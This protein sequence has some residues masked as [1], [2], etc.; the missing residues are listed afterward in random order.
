M[1]PTEADHGIRTTWRK[2]LRGREFKVIFPV[3]AVMIFMGV[4]LYSFA[5]RSV[6]DFANERIREDLERTSR[7][8][9]SICDSAL[10]AL[11][12]T[13]LS[14]NEVAGRIKRGKVLGEIEAYVQQNNLTAI[15]YTNG[16]K[17]VLFSNGSEL[18]IRHVLSNEINETVV[19]SISFDSKIYYV[20]RFQFELWNWHIVLIK[21]GEVYADLLARVNN[22]YLGTTSILIIAG[23][24]LMYYLKRITKTEMDLQAAKEAAEQA[25]LAKSRFLASASHDLR[26]PM[27]TVSLLAGLLRERS[28]VHEDRDLIDKLKRAVNVM[29]ELFEN[30]L[31][32]SRLDGG[33]IT[34]NISE[35]PIAHLLKMIKANYEPHAAS[36]GLRLRV[37]P[38]SAVIRSDPVLL[39]S[40]LSNLVSNAI[41]YTDRG[42]IL[43]GCSRRGEKLSIKVIDTGIGI[44][45]EHLDEI[46]DEF[47]QLPE[48]RRGRN[49][50]LGLGLSIARRYTD[51]LDHPMC[52]RSVVGSGSMFFVDVPRVEMILS[53]ALS[54]E[55]P[56]TPA[57]ELA[58]AFVV[59]IDDDPHNLAATESLCRK[60]GGRTLAAESLQKAIE[61]LRHHLRVPDLI[62]CDYHLSN[63]QNGLSAVREIR[64][65][66]DEEIPAIFVTGDI[67]I[68][69]ESDISTLP[70]A[71]VL[72]KPVNTDRLRESIEHIQAPMVGSAHAGSVAGRVGAVCRES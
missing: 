4:G 29:E 60:W 23:L 61:E 12:V 30:L 37:S 71:L 55:V 49:N 20:R 40:I 41:R 62:I 18:V 24:L 64:N 38:C 59:I 21:D 58:G 56:P 1:K 53:P 2:L 26:Q 65:L 22:T 16:G 45:K 72:H 11:L 6:S 66:M 50:G 7:E 54:M 39:M 32:I 25:S 34:P 3:V 68:T 70:K 17:N 36:K 15:V 52:L 9:F 13:G 14:N 35:F 27:H 51:L 5:L 63:H 42:K 19:A 10:Q 33:A 8:V 67:S 47:V 44:P 48:S 57:T 69:K 46:F 28:E 43:V 31:E